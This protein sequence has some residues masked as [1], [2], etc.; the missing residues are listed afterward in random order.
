MKDFYGFRD[1]IKMRESSGNYQA[2]NKYGYLGAYQFGRARLLD[3]GISI[4]GYGRDTN[5][6]AYKRAKVVSEKDFLNDKELQ[7]TLFFLHTQNLKKR[8]L[9]KYK[10]RLHQFYRGT[11]LT[12][13]GLVAGAHL[14]G[15][16][17]LAKWL[18]GRVVKDGNGVDVGE[19]I[20][21]FS[22]YDLDNY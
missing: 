20:K 6:E 11:Y 9:Q 18:A 4:N 16:G 8:I 7:D 21:K 10:S 13:S 2:K 14:V 17:G 3:L 22:N 15:L 19:Y 1:A 5:P 12:I